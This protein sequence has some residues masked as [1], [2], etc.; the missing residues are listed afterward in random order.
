MTT[1]ITRRIESIVIKNHGA[2]PTVTLKTGVEGLADADGNPTLKPRTNTLDDIGYELPDTTPLGM[3]LLL[4]LAADQAFVSKI[5]LKY[6]K[7]NARNGL[8][9]V[10]TSASFDVTIPKGS[11]ALEKDLTISGITIAIP[12]QETI[13]GSGEFATK[14]ELKYLMQIISAVDAFDIEEARQA[15]LNS[16]LPTPYQQLSLLP[17][18][19]PNRESI[20]SKSRKA[21]LEIASA[22]TE[23]A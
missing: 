16:E 18:E 3:E 4:R 17:A 11:G 5:Q 12:G 14:D 20:T 21:Q 22:D 8:S 15:Q 9:L 13:E 10:P 7:T 2:T 6:P 1:T 23:A 19:D